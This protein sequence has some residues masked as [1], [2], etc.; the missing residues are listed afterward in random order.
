M[1]YSWLRL[2]IKSLSKQALSQD[3][4]PGAARWLL[5]GLFGFAGRQPGVDRPPQHILELV[6]AAPR[7]RTH[8]NEREVVREECRHLGLEFVV[9]QVALR[10]CQEAGLVEEFGVV[11]REFVEQDLVV[12]LNV[13]G[14]YGDEEQ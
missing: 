9:D 12:G 14:V 5:E 4:T 1:N 13:V 3:L 2:R 10:N 11:G 7:H 8:E 6:E